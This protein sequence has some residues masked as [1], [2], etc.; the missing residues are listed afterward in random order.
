VSCDVDGGAWADVP[1]SPDE[2]RL[3]GGFSVALGGKPVD[4][5]HWNRRAAAGLVKVLALA[6]GRR[7]H[8][9]QVMNAL[10]PDCAVA[11]AM[12]RLH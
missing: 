3:L 11:E 4:A 2:V 1:G 5:S 9:E 12:P 6:A 7:A 10:W 8:R